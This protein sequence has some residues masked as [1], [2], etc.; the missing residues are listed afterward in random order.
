[1]PAA[2]PQS[3]DGSAKAAEKGNED[4]GLKKAK[5]TEQRW[6]RIVGNDLESIPLVGSVR[7]LT[8]YFDWSQVVD[9][10]HHSKDARKTSFNQSAVFEPLRNFDSNIGH[11]HDET[12]DENELFL[13][14]DIEPEATQMLP[15]MSDEIFETG[16]RKHS[17]WYGAF[18]ET[19]SQ[20][21]QVESRYSV[22][23]R[24]F[25]DEL[26]TSTTTVSLYQSHWT[27]IRNSCR[28]AR[29]TL[30]SGNWIVKTTSVLFLGLVLEFIPDADFT[31]LVSLGIVLVWHLIA[32]PLEIMC[33]RMASLQSIA[34]QETVM[35]YRI[36]GSIV[37]TMPMNFQQYTN[38]F[39]KHIIWHINR[40]REFFNS[41]ICLVSISYS[42]LAMTILDTGIVS[43][44][45]LRW[46][47]VSVLMIGIVVALNHMSFGV[48]G[49]V[50]YIHRRTDS[51]SLTASLIF[52]MVWFPTVAAAAGFA[53]FKSSNNLTVLLVIIL[54]I[55][56][57]FFQASMFVYFKLLREWVEAQ[58][59][60][61]MF[62]IEN[63]LRAIAMITMHIIVVI[64][65]NPSNYVELVYTSFGACFCALV[66]FFTWYYLFDVSTSFQVVDDVGRVLVHMRG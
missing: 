35:F 22:S 59:F 43:L 49:F 10:D 29:M 33:F 8:H 7:M 26:N 13:S 32:I 31:V 45:Y 21:S 52:W 1:M 36:K 38:N 42:L 14:D 28:M 17:H 25:F 23:S 20:A 24:S 66:L 64:V 61:V 2:G 55:L 47:K 48:I 18:G 44:S 41:N 62:E 57:P 51:L 65:D 30:S 3:F 12:D 60:D 5:E 37:P 46:R 56:P 6:T 11:M 58:K 19:T 39:V 15:K 50:E 53:F 40:W 27:K 9:R 63:S 16:N 4:K 54:L 34:L